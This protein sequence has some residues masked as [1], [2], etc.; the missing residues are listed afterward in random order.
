MNG[1]IEFCTSFDN[2]VHVFGVDNVFKIAKHLGI[3]V[4]I[5]DRNSEAY[6]KEVSVLYE[7]VRF[8]ALGTKE[9]AEGNNESK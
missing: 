9:E 2:G 5:K 6:K 8:F 4:E 1:E 3:S 7:G